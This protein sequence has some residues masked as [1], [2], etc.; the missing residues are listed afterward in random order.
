MKIIESNLERNFGSENGRDNKIHESTQK[1]KA[2]E[3]VKQYWLRNRI[4]IVAVV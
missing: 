2:S 3:I 1:K 4:R